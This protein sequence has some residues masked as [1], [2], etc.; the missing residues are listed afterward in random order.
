MDEGRSCVKEGL[1]TDLGSRDSP[2]SGPPNAGRERR[3]RYY[4][5]RAQELRELAA[6]TRHAD[7]RQDL[8]ALSLR[9]EHL[10]DRAKANE[11]NAS[12]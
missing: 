6:R 3:E 4:R 8:L 7:V 11:D 9:Y 10:A 5:E 2:Y 12:N 1:G